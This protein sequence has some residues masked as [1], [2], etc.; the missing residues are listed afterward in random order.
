MQT[1][2]V[3]VQR[4]HLE[5]LARTRPLLGIAELIWNG[6]D[7]EAT[8]V[9]VTLQRNPLGGVT[10]VL[11][12]DNGHGFT[13]QQALAEFG[14]LGGSW[15]SASKTTRNGQ[16][17]LHGSKGEGRFRA[18]AVGPEI[19][20]ESVSLTAEGLQRTIIEGDLADIGTFHVEDPEPVD[21]STYTRVSIA[22]PQEGTASLAGDD[23]GKYLLSQLAV[24]LSTYPSINVTYDSKQLNPSE[25]QTH[26]HRV[27]LEGLDDAADL[28]VIEWQHPVERALYLCDENG[29]TLLELNAGIHAPGFTFTTYVLS[30]K[31]AQVGVTDVVVGEMHPEI[32]PIVDAARSAMREY[33]KSR[34]HAN[35]RDLINKWKD[36]GTYPFPGEPQTPVDEARRETFEVL[37]VELSDKVPDFGGASP[38]ATKLSLRL[39][40]EAI[41]NSPEALSRILDEVLTLN[42]VEQEDF[43]ALLERTT[44]SAMIRASRVVADRLDFCIGLEELV[45]NPTTKKALLERSQLHRILVDETWLWGD[46]F[47]LTVDDE[48]LDS[49]LSKHLSLLGRESMNPASVEVPEQTAGI[50]DLMLSRLR[51][52]IRGT[53][54]HL[55]VELKR[56]SAKIGSEELTQIKKYAY[57]VAGDERFAGTEA[58][59]TFWLV[60][61]D[62]NTFAREDIEQENR[63]SGLLVDKPAVKVWVM[64]WSQ[65]LDSARRR[66]GFFQEQLGYTPSAVNAR[67]YLHRKH[68]EYLPELSLKP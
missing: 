17:V 34:K 45:F 51:T 67:E 59:W 28:I 44:L 58:R 16:R 49:V 61:N 65:V 38:Q 15:K 39:L 53:R 60:S 5:R 21:N 66:L 54:E 27:A 31:V 18:F 56:P 37:A 46:E 48:S 30:S 23:A 52:D 22:V 24:Y 29:F 55:V 19:R 4:D 11:V 9:D 1:V 63:P 68:E 25:V 6:L 35:R 7:A 42:E 41:E 57:A 13:H 32:Q 62:L 10:N 2:Q 20:W 40:R 43:A 3:E 26:F 36:E 64:T 12:H 47:Y 14:S 33:F 8:H 50:V